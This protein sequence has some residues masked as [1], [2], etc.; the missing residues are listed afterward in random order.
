MVQDKEK[1]VE[2]KEPKIPYKPSMFRMAIFLPFMLIVL[3]FLIWG[4]ARWSEFTRDPIQT[5]AVYFQNPFRVFYIVL[6]WAEGVLAYLA[7][8][9]FS[10]PKDE[11]IGN[12]THWQNHWWETVMGIS[13]FSDSRGYWISSGDAGIRWAGVFILLL[14]LF[15]EISARAMRR[16]V[17]TRQPDADYPRGGIF[18]YMRF[19][20][21]LELLLQSFGIALVFNSAAGLFAGLIFIGVILP[22]VLEQDRIMLRKY[23]ESWSDYQ[24]HVSRLI[25]WV[26]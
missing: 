25:P 19:P 3:A 18:E 1:G 2:T 11:L 4:L 22:R 6:L 24:A 7:S 23:G 10:R 21:I 16:K 8:P 9:L 26:W 13:V 12:W 15:V 17:D 14:A 20:E 5:L